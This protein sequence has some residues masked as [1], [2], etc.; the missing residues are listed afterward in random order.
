MFRI[1]IFSFPSLGDG[2]IYTSIAENFSRVGHQVVLYSNLISHIDAW[3]PNITVN[4]VPLLEKE[5]IDN[6]YDFIISDARCEFVDWVCLPENIKI[7][8]KT[9]LISAQSAEKV[10]KTVFA[11]KPEEV[12]A[13]AKQYSET[14]DELNLNNLSMSLQDIDSSG[15]MVDKAVTWC[16]QVLGQTCHKTVKLK[17]PKHLI[18]KKYPERIIISPQSP[19]PKK[20]W[21]AK[22]FLAVAEQLKSQGYQAV[23][24]VAPAERE[25]WLD[26]LNK[27]FKLPFFAT[28]E[29]LASYIYESSCVIANDSGNGHLASFL[30]IPV[31][32][33]FRKN[34]AFRWQAGWRRAIVVKPMLVSKLLSNKSWRAFI[35]TKMVTKAVEQALKS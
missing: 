21:S 20:N 34:K 12:F 6:S 2:L 25:L 33:I 32:T 24:V 8:N 4:T 29:E 27:Q 35:T 10:K 11:S 3:L 22:G 19:Y 15:T 7:L 14:L 9:T 17:I 23:F 31:V 26:K 18:H 28:I 16:Q 30:D 13:L 5:F 1:A